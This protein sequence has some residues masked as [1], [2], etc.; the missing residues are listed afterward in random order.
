I[1]FLN[2][3]EG[4]LVPVLVL[5]LMLAILIIIF[6]LI[7]KE[8]DLGKDIVVHGEKPIS[9]TDIRYGKVT[10]EISEDSTYKC[11][12]APFSP[13]FLAEKVLVQLA[14]SRSS[15]MTSS[16]LQAVTVWLEWA[17][18]T[19]FSAC[20]ETS[21]RSDKV[22]V[23]TVHWL[24][25]RGQP[26]DGAAGIVDIPFWTSGTSHVHISFPWELNP[27]PEVFVTPVHST[28]HQRKDAASVWS[29]DVTTFGFKLYLREVTNFSGG[30]ANIRVVSLL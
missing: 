11:N 26:Q 16:L 5:L 12:S 24:A 25:L 8:P 7:P 1:D 27:V 2:S 19:G 28:P 14:P 13:P 18:A 3:F 23:V 30:H 4:L 21:G 22:R 6:F 29:E 15:A 10:F 9:S 17:N 20:V